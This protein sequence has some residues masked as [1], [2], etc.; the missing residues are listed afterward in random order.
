MSS[1]TT[2]KQALALEPLPDKDRME[3]IGPAMY[4]RVKPSGA[5]AYVQRLQ[6]GGRTDSAL[7][8]LPRP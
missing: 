2:E 4:L 1:I 8:C 5:R 3:R 7:S 6:H